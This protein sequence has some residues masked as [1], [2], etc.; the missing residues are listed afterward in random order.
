MRRNQLRWNQF[1][2]WCCTHRDVIN[3]A[4]RMCW[5]SL[6]SM[7][8]HRDADS[9][10]VVDQRRA[11]Y[12]AIWRPLRSDRLAMW[13]RYRRAGFVTHRSERGRVSELLRRRIQRMNQ[14]DKNRASAPTEPDK[15]VPVTIDSAVQTTFNPLIYNAGN[16]VSHN[17]EIMIPPRS[18]WSSQF[19]PVLTERP[20]VGQPLYIVNDQA[21]FSGVPGGNLVRKPRV[22][23]V[24]QPGS[25]SAMG[26]RAVS[27]DGFTIMTVFI[28]VSQ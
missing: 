2:K 20:A 5:Y 18:V 21:R 9:Q 13:R 15:P 11:R 25:R 10:D 8:C 4:A 16:L 27:T 26:F 24:P 23:M 3:Q 14:F 6:T 7:L 28:P 22:P 17:P 12:G 1:W 19:G